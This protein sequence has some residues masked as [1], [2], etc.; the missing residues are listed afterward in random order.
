M[1]A[2]CKAEALREAAEHFRSNAAP[3]WGGD[4]T[5]ITTGSHVAALV[6]A[7][8]EGMAEEVDQ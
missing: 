8:L 3:A 4:A 6:A 2:A 1:S 5:W 7:W